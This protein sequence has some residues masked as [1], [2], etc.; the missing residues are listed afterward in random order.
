MAHVRRLEN[1]NSY[2]E[3]LMI[4]KIQVRQLRGGIHSGKTLGAL[5]RIFVPSGISQAEISRDQR[6]V[7]TGAS[8]GRS[9]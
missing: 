4:D 1:W 7:E 2:L 3:E 8:G 6:V 5:L 9:G